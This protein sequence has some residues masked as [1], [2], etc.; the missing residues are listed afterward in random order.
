MK[1]SMR[2]TCKDLSHKG[3]WLLHRENW[4]VLLHRENWSLLLYIEKSLILW[5]PQE[6]E[7]TGVVC[8]KGKV[9]GQL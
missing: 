9:R 2:I 7:K 6:N 5:A 8:Y 1:W 3:K 4:S